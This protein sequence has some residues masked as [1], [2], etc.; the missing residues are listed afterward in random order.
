MNLKEH[1]KHGSCRSCGGLTSSYYDDDGT[2][3]MCCWRCYKLQMKRCGMCNR[4]WLDEYHT[5]CDVCT[6]GICDSCVMEHT[7]SLSSG[8]NCN[9]TI[10][11]DPVCL[12]MHRLVCNFYNYGYSA[13]T[14]KD[15]VIHSLERSIKR[16]Q[17]HIAKIKA[18]TSDSDSSDSEDSL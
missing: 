6:K 8:Y 2:R 14:Y 4:E 9:M 17:K 11:I 12:N 5:R 18:I 13:S 15:K 3:V 1:Y 7:G 10:C 16:T